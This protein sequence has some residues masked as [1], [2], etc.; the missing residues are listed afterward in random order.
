MLEGAEVGGWQG[1]KLGLLNAVAEGW[2]YLA[3]IKKTH[4]P[5]SIQARHLPVSVLS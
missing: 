1:R 4:K 2:L 3:Q 5:C